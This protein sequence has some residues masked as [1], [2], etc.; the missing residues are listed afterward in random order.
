MLRVR[1]GPPPTRRIREIERSEHLARTP[2]VA[3][4][5]NAMAHHV[6]EYLGAGM[7]GVASKPINL[8]ELLAVIQSAMDKAG[9]A[10]ERL[11]G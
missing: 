7:D 6:Q 2:I 3:L 1:A 4:T 11:A 5:A 8:P 10:A 9:R